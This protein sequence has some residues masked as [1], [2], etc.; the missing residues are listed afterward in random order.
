MKYHIYAKFLGS[1][2]PKKIAKIGDCKILKSYD[3]YHFD[4]DRPEIPV[5]SKDTEFHYLEK[6]VRNYIYYPQEL[7]SVRTFES[8]YLIVTEVESYSEYDALKKA[9]DKFSDV[10]AS[11]SLVAKNKT[12]KLGKKRIK[13]GDEI[14][15]FEIIGIFIKKGG[16]FIRLK[17]PKPFINCRNFF[18][19]GFPKGF[20]SQAKKYLQFNDLVFRKGLIY[21]QRATAMRYSGVFSDL[22]IILNFVKCIELICWNIGED[23][24]FGLSR[25]KFENLSTKE[26]IKHAG[27]KMKVRLKTIKIAKKAWDVRSKGD[28]AHRYLYFNPY[29]KK[30]V[31]VLMNYIDL[32]S[33][34]AEFLRKYYKY[35]VK[36]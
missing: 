14:Y 35:R 16:R 11:L 4:D 12:V 33:C 27:R 13:K 28:V 9:S 36:S 31:N 8:E 20:L 30:S 1:Y 29:D 3:Q 18:P 21:F 25:K 32:E 24:R 22:E 17:L 6:G 19:K 23:D 2:M 15:D 7:I 34:V 5:R 10:V 26:V